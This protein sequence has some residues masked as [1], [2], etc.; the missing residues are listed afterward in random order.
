ME[1]IG[2]GIS[3]DRE[4]ALRFDDFPKRAHNGLLNRIES[5]TDRLYSLVAARIPDRTGRLRSK[6]DKAIYDDRDRI[7]GRVSFSG[8]FAKAGALEYGAHRLTK[9]KAHAMQ[10]DHNWSTKLQRPTKVI[11]AAYSRT[12]DIEAV[13]ML[14]GPLAQISSAAIEGMQEEVD[15]LASAN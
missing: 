9:V 14:R 13:K 7:S 8:D 4:V 12:P 5:L 3:G 15:E 1:D 10:L 2:V 11:V 6:I